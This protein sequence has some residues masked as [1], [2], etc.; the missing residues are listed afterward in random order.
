MGECLNQARLQIQKVN[1]AFQEKEKV[2]E[3]RFVKM[4]EMIKNLKNENEELKMVVKDKNETFENSESKNI[5]LEKELEKLKI[6]NK[7]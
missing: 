7:V 3:Y 5:I 2:V 4:E 1:R 6:E